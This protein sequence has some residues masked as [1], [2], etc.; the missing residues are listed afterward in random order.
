MLPRPSHKQRK[1]R[2]H[3]GGFTLV[4]LLVVLVILS[5]VMGLVGPRVL[6]YLT[7]ARARSANLQIES[8]AGAMDLFFLDMGRYPSQGEGLE[9][10]VKEQPSFS[11]WNGPYLQKSDLP[12]DPWGNPYRYKAPDPSGNYKII[13][14]GSDGR[15]GGEDD[16]ADIVS[17]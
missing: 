16:A 1:Q 12:Q 11:G 4:E 13:S 3:D 7:D 5:M 14:L 8:L 17:Q 15:E 10:L 2:D 9:A 6:G